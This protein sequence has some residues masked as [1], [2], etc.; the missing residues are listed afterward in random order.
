MEEII[1]GRAES[2]CVP[3]FTAEVKANAYEKHL[4]FFEQNAGKLFPQ[5]H[6]AK[7][8]EEIEEF[9]RVLEHEG[10]TVRR[11]KILDHTEVNVIHFIVSAPRG[12]FCFLESLN[13]SRDE[14]EKNIEIRGKTNYLPGVPKKLTGHCLISCDVKAI[15]AIA[16]K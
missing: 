3:P 12:K 15:K 14:V 1:V 7:A 9:C 10:V 2:A 11:P 4:P 8:V 5:E 13:V 16:M 6:V